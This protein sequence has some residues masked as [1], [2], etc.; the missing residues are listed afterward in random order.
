MDD[1]SIESGMRTAAA[2]VAAGPAMTAAIKNTLVNRRGGIPAEA[3]YERIPWG[4]RLAGEGAVL[5]YLSRHDVSHIRSVRNAPSAAGQAKNVLFEAR[6]LNRARGVADMKWHEQLAARGRNLVAGHVGWRGA[7]ASL[8]KGGVA[9]AIA[10]VP[11]SMTIETLHVVNGQKTASR[12]VLDGAAA[13]GTSAAAGGIASVG[14]MGAATA[15]TAV[16]LP[17]TAPVLGT[18][19]GIGAGAYVY[20]SAKR[21]LDALAPDAHT[22]TR[23]TVSEGLATVEAAIE[24]AQSRVATELAVAYATFTALVDDMP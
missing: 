3:L 5:D 6:A 24:R 10:E 11:L 8:G 14:L 20:T 12:A 9:G 17:I 18:V 1:F 16:G 2:Y 13:V 22:A 21:V 23:E 19:A 15:A 7:A 4:V